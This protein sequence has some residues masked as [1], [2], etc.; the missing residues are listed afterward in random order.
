VIHLALDHTFHCDVDE[1]WRRFFDDALNDQ[2]FLE[3][4]QFPVYRV[5]EC[6]DEGARL[7]RRLEVTPRVDMALVGGLVADQLRYREDG[8]F[9]K[10]ERTYRFTTRPPDGSDRLINEGTIRAVASA[11]G[12]RRLAEMT[13]RSHVRGFAAAI[14]KV[15]A[16]ATSDGFDAIAK[17]ANRR[18]AGSRR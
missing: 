9:D 17:A 4:L 13:L 8:V 6:R 1:F 14:E 2:I 7:V 18:I 11:D 16:R 12:C 3:D 5:L 10:A 15:A